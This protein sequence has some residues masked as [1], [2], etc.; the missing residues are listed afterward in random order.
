M[1]AA[2][3]ELRNGTKHAMK[4]KVGSSQLATV[5][6]GGKYVIAV[7]FNDTYREYTI[8]IDVPAMEE[9]IVSTDDLCDHKCIT[10]KED[11]DSEG[12]LYLQREPRGQQGEAKTRSERVRNWL[13]SW[14]SK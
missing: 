4:V 7:D 11:D 3:T 9:L 1:G 12:K 13:R 8:S 14:I 2:S 6:A 10:V 5:E